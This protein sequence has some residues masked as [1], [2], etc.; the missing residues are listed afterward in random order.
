VPEINPRL[1]SIA[2]VFA[3]TCIG[4]GM[5]VATGL[6]HGRL[7]QRWGPVPDLQAA[8]RQVESL[9][10]TIGD[11]QLVKETPLPAMVQQT[12]SCAG[13]INREYVNR[14]SG[15]TVHIAITVGPSGPIS[16]HTPEI[17]FSSRAYSIHD[18][19]QR[20]TVTDSQGRIHS[21][22][23]LSFR[24]N[25]LS[26]DTLRVY[27]AWCPDVNGIWAAS[28]SPRIEFAGRRVLFKL[29]MSTLV[30][31]LAADQAKDPCQEFLSALLHARP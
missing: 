6:V 4:V 17:C 24:S 16:V 25:D 20:E 10:K 23:S 2:I 22:W 29:Q 7:A 1:R 3:L 14:K 31:P 26:A 28:E 11:W 19:R 18:P 21:I 5:T 12:L 9:P 27:Y 8:A 30:S 15:E 13:Y